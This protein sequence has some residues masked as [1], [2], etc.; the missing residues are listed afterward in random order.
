[1]L[2]GLQ[3][4]KELPGVQISYVI[5]YF[6][7]GLYAVETIISHISNPIL[8]FNYGVQQSYTKGIGPCSGEMYL[9]ISP[10]GLTQEH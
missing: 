9:Y 10:H 4:D 5:I 7:L 1:M 3:D 8:V 2:N 6:Y